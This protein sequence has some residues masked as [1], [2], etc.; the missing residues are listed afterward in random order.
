VVKGRSRPKNHLYDEGGGY[1]AS[2]ASFKFE[3]EAACC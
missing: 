3:A 1:D 2:G